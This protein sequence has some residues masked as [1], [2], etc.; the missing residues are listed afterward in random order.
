MSNYLFILTEKALDRKLR[1][2][3]A[4]L[5]EGATDEVVQRTDLFNYTYTY[6]S[7]EITKAYDGDSL[8]FRG[9]YVDYRTGEIVF[10]INGRLRSHRLATANE[11]YEG[12]YV[13]ISRTETEVLV[14]HDI[15]GNGVVL[16]TQGTGYVAISDSL[17]TLAQFRNSMGDTCE[18][19][20][21]V[22]LSRTVRNI[23]ASSQLGPETHVQG[24]SFLPATQSLR[25]TLAPPL[26]AAPTN[27]TAPALFE[28]GDMSY[29]ELLRTTAVGMVKLIL[30]LHQVPRWNLR[31]NLSG[32]YDSRAILAAVDAAGLLTQIGISCR[33]TGPT[34]E[35]DYHVA[36]VLAKHF[37]FQ[38][39][40]RSNR[41][42][43]VPSRQVPCTPSGLW[44]LSS[45]GLYDKLTIR[46]SSRARLN[47]FSMSG[48]AGE[49]SRGNFG[50]LS[51]AAFAQTLNGPASALQALRGQGENALHSLG[52]EVDHP[53]GSEWHYLGFR[54][55]LH[56]GRNT[57]TN[58]TSFLP[59]AA[60]SLVA[61]GRSDNAP[62][63]KPGKYGPNAINDLTAAMSP[64]AAAL[65]YDRPEKNMSIGHVEARH[66]S[67]GGLPPPRELEPF[68]LLGTPE[69]VPVGPP[70]VLLNLLN[71]LELD[72]SLTREGAVALAEEGFST[73]KQIPELGVAYES[74][75]KRVRWRL[76][77]KRDPVLATSA[78]LGKLLCL[79]AV[80][81]RS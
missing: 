28:A 70:N 62:F 56:N 15:F 50:W 68:H 9:N 24:V 72:Q 66:Q 33:N 52:V 45:L 4:S 76:L 2:W 58:M 67:L 20:E 78:D 11:S 31:L 47:D 12:Q 26:C 3:L 39:N 21:T 49:L 8:F 23:V 54:N 81:A 42:P 73:V 55:G 38:L 25:I 57:P 61:A 30:G 71:H 69:D 17:V 13:Q 75:L 80:F 41:Y 36:T 53:Y 5:S 64:R 1:D 77:Q 65:P 16:Y 22:A 34:H 6:I 10:G 27:L 18:L 60:Q 7:H 46:A 48:L 63:Q 19:N 14:T 59:L 74:V 40:A 29:A 35:Q 37:N 32:G 44:F 51:W 79:C 43:D